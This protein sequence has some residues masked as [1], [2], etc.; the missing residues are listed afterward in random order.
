MPIEIRKRKN[1]VLSIG[2]AVT[3]LLAGPVPR[4]LF[5]RDSV[6][7]TLI[8]RPGGDAL[9]VCLNAAALGMDCRLVSCI[10]ADPNGMMIQKAL[11]E[12]G[13]RT[14]LLQVLSHTATAVT[15][16][17]TENSGERHFLTCQDIFSKISAEEI[18]DEVLQKTGFVS[19]N[20]YYRMPLVDG[21]PAAALFHRARA[22]GALTLVDTMHCREGNA[23]ERIL[24]VLAE[25]DLFF[26]S[27]EE[28]RQITGRDTPEEM[29]AVLQETGVG[30]F[31]VKL[32]ERGS[33]V[34][35]FTEHFSIPA[36]ETAKVVGTVGAGDTYCAGFIAAL[37]KGYSLKEA[38][39]FATCACACTVEVPGANGGIKS[40]AQVEERY[41]AYRT[42]H[43]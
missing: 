42:R 8:T 7:V 32:G 5:S 39:A 16:V 10:G 3:D 29:A 28:A 22:L 13:V 20:S 24:P 26:P 6:P 12:A 11:S 33:F 17:V 30:V 27:Y 1:S 21:A 37:A 19:L 2:M 40:F 23:M 9:N 38:A 18:S 15:I 31:A 4:D 43:E 35:D 25:T 34:T 41:Q 36:D 14:D